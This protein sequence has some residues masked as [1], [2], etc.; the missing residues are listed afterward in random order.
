MKKSPPMTVASR[1]RESPREQYIN[2]NI[3]NRILKNFLR[4]RARGWERLPLLIRIFLLRET[5]E[6]GE[7]EIF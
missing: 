2:I 7:D 5:A 1:S 4:S 3:H 6:E